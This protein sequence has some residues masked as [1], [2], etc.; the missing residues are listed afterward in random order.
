VK[1]RLMQQLLIHMGAE[2]NPFL[3]ALQHMMEACSHLM[4]PGCS[5]LKRLCLIPWLSI[6]GIMCHLLQLPSGYLRIGT[7]YCALH[8]HM[9]CRFSAGA[10]LS[11]QRTRTITWSTMLAPCPLLG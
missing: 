10:L 7:C 9:L 4:Q 1:T 5:A 6:V 3:Q 11:N 2:V 8:V